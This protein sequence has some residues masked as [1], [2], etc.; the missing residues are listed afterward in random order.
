M[1]EA[2]IVSLLSRVKGDCMKIPFLESWDMVLPNLVVGKVY[3]LERPMPPLVKGGSWQKWR[4]VITNGNF[5]G[6]PRYQAMIMDT[7]EN[8]GFQPIY[9]DPATTPSTVICGVELF[10]ERNG[11]KFQTYFHNVRKE[12]A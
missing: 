3:T 9:R 4:V 5:A 12:N 2:V 10:F 7:K 1:E 8:V 6:K 11:R